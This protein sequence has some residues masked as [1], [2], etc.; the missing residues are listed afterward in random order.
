MAIKW[1]WRFEGT[2]LDATH[3]HITGAADNT[4]TANGSA[5]LSATAA[6]VGTNGGLFGAGGSDQFRFDTSTDM[7]NRLVGAIAFSLRFSTLPPGGVQGVCN[8]SG[9]AGNIIFQLVNSDIRV[10]TNLEQAGESQVTTD[11]API[12]VNTWAG[13]IYRWDQPNSLR[14][15][16]VY[17]ASN[18]LA[19]STPD[20]SAFTAPADLATSAGL[21]IG[22]T[23]GN[24]GVI[25]IDNFFIADTYA[26]PLEDN[27][28]ITSYTGYG[29][30]GG[31]GAPRFAGFQM[32]MRNN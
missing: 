16:E 25:H 1:F 8:V 14:V 7:V 31:G 3:D 10:I 22:N 15:I 13:V 26:E 19:G 9:A 2:T 4:A 27:F 18:V 11:F 28:T 12:S 5:S 32:M 21:R 24:G 29:G 23:D 6:R 17:N 30:G 20:A